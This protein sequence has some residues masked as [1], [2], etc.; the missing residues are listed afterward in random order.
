MS[1]SASVTVLSPAK[2]SSLPEAAPYAELAVTTKFSFL[3]GGS[4]PSELVGQAH[5]LGLAAIAITDRNSL[6]GVVR[7]YA[8]AKEIEAVVSDVQNQADVT[9]GGDNDGGA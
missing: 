6:A 5:A 7:A 1:T 3:R 8:K 9:A 2:P 4:H